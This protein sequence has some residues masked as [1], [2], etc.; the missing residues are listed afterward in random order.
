VVHGVEGF[1]SEEI[2]EGLERWATCEGLAALLSSRGQGAA[3]QDLG[4]CDRLPLADFCM[5]DI[6]FQGSAV[7]DSRTT[8]PRATRKQGR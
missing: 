1:R 6:L 5:E 8:E 7:K 3:R 2:E 4:S